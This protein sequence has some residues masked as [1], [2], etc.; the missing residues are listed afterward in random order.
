MDPS[1]ASYAVLRYIDDDITWESHEPACHV[2]TRGVCWVLGWAIAIAIFAI[3]ASV[4]IEF[5]H[6][7]AAERS[8]ARAA[9]AAALEASLPRATYETICSVAMRR[10]A[11]QPALASQVRVSL[12]QNGA[13]VGKSFGPQPGD[14]ITVTLAMP[15]S[16]ALP[17][18]LPGV[19]YR[20]SDAPITVRAELEM[21]GKDLATSAPYRI[22]IAR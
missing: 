3:A 17:D 10:L 6:L 4:L 11:A 5:G 13:P 18:W 16:A 21:P 12:L 8:L 7:L 20:R 15:I 14:Q 22:L 9:R 2:P 19:H 1:H